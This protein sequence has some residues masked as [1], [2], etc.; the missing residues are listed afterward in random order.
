MASIKFR[1]RIAHAT[2]EEE[3]QR[4]ALQATLVTPD[5]YA[6]A[7]D[8]RFAA[9]VKANVDGLEGP[10]MVPQE[11]GP[12]S[13]TDLKAEFHANGELACEKRSIVKGQLR[14]ERAEVRNGRFPRVGSVLDKV[15]V[16]KGLVLAINANY[17][18]RL[19]Q[20]INVPDSH[21]ADV[22]ILLIPTPEKGDVVTEVIGVLSNDES[23]HGYGEDAGGFGII[24]PCDAEA[25]AARCD[26]ELL[27]NAAK[28]SLDA[29]AKRWSEAC[30]ERSL[31]EDEAK[32]AP[33]PPKQKAPAKAR[34]KRRRKAARKRSVA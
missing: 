8:G 24:M 22:V 20:A 27:R 31:P 9:C 7:T 11:L 34:P 4:Y 13:K 2:D 23:R 33:V 29:A 14:V 12:K 10:V 16:V 17:L 21:A 18:W 3:S 15:D 19:A 6:V 28:H 1:T 5:G 30:V 25:E 26:F 32:P